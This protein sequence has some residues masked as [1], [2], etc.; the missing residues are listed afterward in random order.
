MRTA[1][2]AALKMS[3]S[4]EAR[5]GL[6]LAGRSVLARQVGLALALGC[7]RV[8]VLAEAPHPALAEAEH[9]S[10][11]GGAAFH[12]LARFAGLAALVHGKDELVVLADGLLPDPALLAALIVPKE[13]AAPLR[14]VVLCLPDDDA[15]ATQFPEDFERIDAARCWAGVA[16]MRGALAQQL[17]DFPDDSDATSLLLRL[18][19]QAGTPCHTLTP[20]E[21]S[22]QAWLLMRDPAEATARE[23]ALVNEHARTAPGEPPSARL[24]AWLARRLTARIGAAALPRA[25]L[26]ALVLGGALWLAALISA[27]INHAVSALMLA[28]LGLIAWRTSADLARLASGLLGAVPSRL[29]VL[30]RSVGGDGLAALT[31]TL[32]L[33]Q[34]GAPLAVAGLGLIAVMGLQLA[35]RSTG[36]QLLPIWRERAGQMALL[37]LGASGEALSAV[38]ALLTIAALAQALFTASRHTIPN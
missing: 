9:E 27:A 6:A 31:L 4:G 38:A 29:R 11:A 37:A 33:A 26:A 15:Q 16:V 35:E 36:E 8:I 14:R 1:L 34:P 17:V 20:L 22:P 28:A 32:A 19:L 3:P 5:A 10:R 7:E 18:A 12:N 30:L 24:A 21:R 2:L 13:P 25:E 23:V